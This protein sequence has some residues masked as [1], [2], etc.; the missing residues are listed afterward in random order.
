MNSLWRNIE[1]VQHNVYTY[2]SNQRLQ[3]AK[4]VSHT[5]EETRP[6]SN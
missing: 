1:Y 3:N 4:P 6:T 2:G 5:L